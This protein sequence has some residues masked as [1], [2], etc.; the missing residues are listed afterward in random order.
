MSRR[1]RKVSRILLG[2]YLAAVFFLCFSNMSSLPEVK[3]QLLG[4]D[5][6]KVAHFLMFLPL[7]LLVCF[8][9]EGKAWLLA[10]AGLLSGALLGG[11]TELVQG[12]LTYR[13][14]DIVDFAADMAGSVAG[15]CLVLCIAPVIKAGK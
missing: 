12:F 13:S 14:M 1:T 6:D 9:F 10:L 4:M 5:A 7:P 11:A 15:A 3:Q 8:S 2:I